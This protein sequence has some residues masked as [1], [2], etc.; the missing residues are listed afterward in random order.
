M[1]HVK[2]LILSDSGDTVDVLGRKLHSNGRQ[3][4]DVIRVLQSMRGFESC[5]RELNRMTG[6][7]DELGRSYRRVGDALHI[8]SAD[9]RTSERKAEEGKTGSR[10]GLRRRADNVSVSGLKKPKEGSA[11]RGVLD[12]LSSNII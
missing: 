4:E 10:N 6:Q 1:F 12:T 8:V 11:L 2:P 5:L 7:V 3:V 9:Y